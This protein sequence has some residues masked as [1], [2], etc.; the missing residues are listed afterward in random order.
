[1]QLIDGRPVYAATDLVGFLACAHLTDLERASIAGL[2]R[3]PHRADPQPQV[4]EAR[5]GYV[6]TA[7]VRA[8]AE[9]AGFVFDGASEV[10]ANPNDTADHPE[11]VWEMPPTLAT[12][13]EELTALGESDRMTL[14]FRKR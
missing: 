14:L 11:G 10:N 1:M 2:V 4:P 13:R 5:N 3:R 12:K 6:A 8:L 9:K 7:T